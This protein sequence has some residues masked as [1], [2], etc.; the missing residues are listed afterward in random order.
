MRT[1]LSA[2][3]GELANIFKNSGATDQEIKALGALNVDSTPNDVKA[4]I[5]AA[6]ALMGSRIGAVEDSYRDDMGT[7]KQG[8]FLR[9]EA[10][11]ALLKLQQQGFN[12]KIPQLAEAPQV[13]LQMFHDSD[14]KS[15]AM[16]DQLVAADPS[17]KSDPQK[18]LSTLAENG[19]QL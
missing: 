3:S 4:Y 12:I 17:L 18:M 6:T 13:R 11:G 1:D 16:L 10:V 8:G 19:I 7:Q 9:P 14:P 2:V 5:E 15:A